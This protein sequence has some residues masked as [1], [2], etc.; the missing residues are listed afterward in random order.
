MFR[1]ACDNSVTTSAASQPTHSKPD[2]VEMPAG[3]TDLHQTRP[4]Q[5]LSTA[6]PPRASGSSQTVTT[7]LPPSARP[8]PLRHRPCHSPPHTR[9]SRTCRR[10]HSVPRAR[11][12]PPARSRNIPMPADDGDQDRVIVVVRPGQPSAGLASHR[13]NVNPPGTFN[14]IETEPSRHSNRAPHGA[15]GLTVDRD[16]ADTPS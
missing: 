3:T 7:T 5:P 8:N 13:L 1:T 4:G 10:P 9:D 2:H 15:V 11:H 6:P 14:H 16:L 12:G